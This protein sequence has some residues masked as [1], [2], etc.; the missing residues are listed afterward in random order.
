[1]ESTMKYELINLNLGENPQVREFSVGPYKITLLDDYDTLQSQL[2]EH[3]KLTHTISYLDGQEIKQTTETKPRQGKA[4]VTATAE[5]DEESESAFYDDSPRAIWDLCAILSFLLG[6]RVFLPGEERF[7]VI[8]HF[9][10]MA[11]PYYEVH[12]IAAVAWSNRQSFSSETERLPLWYYLSMNDTPVQQIKLLLGCVSLEIMQN[13]DEHKI[14]SPLSEE[15]LERLR[16]LEQLIGVIQQ[17][18]DQSSIDNDLKNRLKSTVGNWGGSSAQEAFKNMLINFGL[19]DSNIS[20]IPLKRV[21]GINRMRNAV[22]HKGELE[23]PNW[24]EDPKAQIRSGAFVRGRFI[25]AL[26]LDYLNRKLGLHEFEYVKRNTR[27]LR[28]YIY[29]GTH[30]GDPIEI[31]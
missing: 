4:L 2:A 17:Q 13:L 19:I 15:E 22:V 7:N 3:T 11:V 29:I 26:V 12:K 23:S 31:P 21:R 20:G 8:N 6:R 10:F 28:E 9:G 27:I 5:C 30:E 18:I 1:M 16:K 25:P 24:I 14:E